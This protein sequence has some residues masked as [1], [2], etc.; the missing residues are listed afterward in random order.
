MMQSL[1]WLLAT[2]GLLLPAGVPGVWLPVPDVALVTPQPDAGAAGPVLPA[3]VASVEP[4]M[5]VA[6]SEQHRQRP[7]PIE[8]SDAYF[9]RL[10]I[11]YIASFATLPL[12]VAEY[13]VGR[14]LY[15]N[16]DSASR[17]LRGWHNNLALAIGGLFTLNTVTGLW[18]MWESRHDPAGRARRYIHGFSM[19]AADAGF[20]AT[21]RMTPS[22][23][24]RRSGGATGQSS[25]N[26]HRAIAI[27]SM[28]VSL[29]SYVMMLFWK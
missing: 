22:R 15:N 9:V 25:A 23:D 24:F 28:S 21:A 7:R 16:P 13:F 20:L 18:N 17:S 1:V 29:A 11:H 5:A 27:S 2:S 14:S 3:Y 6:D 26:T 12:F 19:L 8:Y 4:A 10:K